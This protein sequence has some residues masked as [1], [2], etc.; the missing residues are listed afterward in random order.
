MTASTKSATT[1]L[2]RSTTTPSTPLDSTPSTQSKTAQ[3]ANSIALTQKAS[4]TKLTTIASVT[5]FKPAFKHDYTIDGRKF[6]NPYGTFIELSDSSKEIQYN[7][8]KN[9]WLIGRWAYNTTQWFRENTT[10]PIYDGIVNYYRARWGYDKNQKYVALNEE[11]RPKAHDRLKELWEQHK[12]EIKKEYN[13]TIDDV[14]SMYVKLPPLIDEKPDPKGSYTFIV[15]VR[16]KDENGQ[17]KTDENGKFITKEIKFVKSSPESDSDDDQGDNFLLLLEN[18]IHY[19]K[20]AERHPYT[21]EEFDKLIKKGGLPSSDQVTDTS[22]SK[23]E[24]VTSN[25]LQRTKNDCWLHAGI[26]G[27]LENIR[28]KKALFKLPSN[29]QQEEQLLKSKIEADYEASDKSQTKEAF[30]KSKREAFALHKN[31]TKNLIACLQKISTP[32]NNVDNKDPVKFMNYASQIINQESAEIRQEL[33]AKLTT[34][35]DAVFLTHSSI[36]EFLDDLGLLS[37]VSIQKTPTLV[38]FDKYKNAEIGEKVKGNTILEHS[39]ELDLNSYANKKEVDT[40]NLINEFNNRSCDYLLEDYSIDGIKHDWKIKNESR[41]FTK[42]PEGCVSFYIK[43]FSANGTK[44]TA[45]LTNVPLELNYTNNQF[46]PQA[47][48]LYKLRYAIIHLGTTDNGHYYTI[49]SDE[50]GKWFKDDTGNISKIVL[51]EVFESLK[52]AVY[53]HYDN[54]QQ[55]SP[56]ITPSAPPIPVPVAT[57]AA[58]PIPAITSP[59]SAKPALTQTAQGWGSWLKSLAGY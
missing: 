13:C 44:V 50:N 23:T 3:V 28:I 59:A 45:S 35:E 53:L 29:P 33:G 1:P 37:P 2:L 40:E 55:T 51:Q 41:E 8:N 42:D 19:S 56:A 32:S 25:A 30:E 36:I 10:I 27:L 24:K 48:G 9:D 12:D 11:E 5:E 15:K 26:C 21:K 14:V 31:K 43:R 58:A 18:E 16:E 47:R 54:E 4:T 17:A 6:V 46:K 7:N 57:P 39:L 20:F 49:F 38:Q 52:N 22:T 34:Q